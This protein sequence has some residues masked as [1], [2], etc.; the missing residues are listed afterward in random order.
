MKK[1]ILTLAVLSF[2][3]VA[4][5]Q[6]NLVPNPSFEVHDTCPNMPGDIR[7]A[8][9]WFQPNDP[10]SYSSSSTDYFNSCA[11]QFVGVPSNI[12]GYQ[13]PRTGSGYGGF[14]AYSTQNDYYGHEYLETNLS[15]PLDSGGRYCVSFYVALSNANGIC[16]TS[17]IGAYFSQDTCQY[18]SG[19]YFPIN[20]VPQF[21]NDSN[22]ILNDSVNWTLVSGTFISQGLESYI[23][24]GN[25]WGPSYNMTNGDPSCS[26]APYYYIDDV[27]LVKLPNLNA[28]A[29][30]VITFGDTTVLQGA[31]SEQWTGMTFEWMPHFGIDDP[32][33]LVTTAHPDSTTSYVLTVS[34]AT[35]EVP[36]L[37]EV[38]DSVTIFVQ[39]VEPPPTIP[40]HV[41]TLFNTDQHFQVDSL[42][43]NSRLK[44][45][46]VRGRLVYFCE[47][48][49]NDFAL[50]GL[51]SSIY[52][53]EIELADTR[54]FTG[55]FA[56]MQR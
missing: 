26:G 11:T 52:N 56:I 10:Q 39:N 6:V 32:Y 24:I 3:L 19:G 21:V 42:P 55:K 1:G 41:Q 20:V 54:I 15:V 44:I 4:I 28:G 27:S 22:S 12:I 29:N 7:N 17:A 50:A 35:C 40:F 33:T 25:Y 38:V 23:T 2:S 18:I 5:S 30:R 46:D 9:P 37:G 8:V 34:C 45:Y 49:N 13:V 53:Y 48:Y 43:P 14:A 51:N 31:I 47:N 36:C 16:G